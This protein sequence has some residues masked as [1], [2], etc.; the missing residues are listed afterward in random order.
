MNSYRSRNRPSSFHHYQYSFC[1]Q[2]G[3]V[4]T[5]PVILKSELKRAQRSYKYKK[6]RSNP[7]IQKVH[8]TCLLPPRNLK[9][10]QK[11]VHTN[12]IPTMKSHI[13]N[14]NCVFGSSL[15][16]KPTTQL[17]REAFHLPPCLLSAA[18]FPAIPS[19]SL[20]SDITPP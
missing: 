18:A 3:S 6:G 8:Q 14:V 16:T 1:F 9:S 11:T 12:V 20:G 19:E 13:P 17:S 7:Y 15:V 2:N 5:G 4:S 10:K